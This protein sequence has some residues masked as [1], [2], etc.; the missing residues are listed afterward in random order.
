MS[1]QLPGEHII[2]I[3]SDCRNCISTSNLLLWDDH[4][5]Q[6]NFIDLLK[7]ILYPF[8]Y[9][10]VLDIV[11]AVAR[12]AILFFVVGGRLKSFHSISNYWIYLLVILFSALIGVAVGQGHL[13]VFCRWF[14][15]SLLA[16]VIGIHV[17]YDKGISVSDEELDD[18][19]DE[20]DQSK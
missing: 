16:G 4:M 15:C 5:N 12:F 19:Q 2:D 11:Y 10:F 9:F 17:G 7:T 18:L 6:V 13:L 20:V 3:D 8:G 1:F 14:I